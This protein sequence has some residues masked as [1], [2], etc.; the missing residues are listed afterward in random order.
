MTQPLNRNQKKTL[1]ERLISELREAD[2]QL[3]ALDDL[4]DFSPE[5]HFIVAV[6]R[7]Y[8]GYIRSVSGLL[9]DDLD[10]VQRFCLEN[11]YGANAYPVMRGDGDCQPVHTLDD[12]LDLM[13]A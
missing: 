8:D 7:L 12:L 1:L 3:N 11:N 4:L 5:S 10:W 13:E 2:R 6:H 9:D